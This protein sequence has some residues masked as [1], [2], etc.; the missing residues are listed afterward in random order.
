ML[1]K[2][3]FQ[4]QNARP[5]KPL[6]NL[7]QR[8]QPFMDAWDQALQD[9]VVEQA[10]YDSAS[11]HVYLHCYV[12]RTRTRFV[13]IRQR[14]EDAPM[15]PQALLDPGHAGQVL[16]QAV[17]T[18]LFMFNFQYLGREIQYSLLVVIFTLIS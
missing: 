7:M 8:M 1:K 5:R 13:S 17:R 4:V 9:R 11:Y 10:P 6:A 16:H 18:F 12:P 2:M 14:Q 3:F 15:L